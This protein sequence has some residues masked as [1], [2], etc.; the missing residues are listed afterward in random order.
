MRAGRKSGAVNLSERREAQRFK[1]DWAIKVST[2]TE[3]GS[4]SEETGMLADISSTGAYGLFTNGYDVGAS[5]RVMIK[6]P[7]RRKGWISYPARILRV[8]PCDSGAGVAFI[9]DAVRPSFVEDLDQE[10]KQ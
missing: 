8:E 4:A 9:F 2:W 7:L 10:L 3:D 1:V 5:V 6:L